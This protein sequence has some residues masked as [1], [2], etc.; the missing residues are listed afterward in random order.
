MNVRILGIIFSLADDKSVDSEYLFTYGEF[1]NV[2]VCQTNLLEVFVY[3][4]MSES[5]IRDVDKQSLGM[6][7]NTSL[8]KLPLK[9][10]IFLGFLKKRG[11][12]HKR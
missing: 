12:T 4:P 2:K 1:I 8:L 7:E 9:I 3:R 5:K 6:Q 10:K 11:Y